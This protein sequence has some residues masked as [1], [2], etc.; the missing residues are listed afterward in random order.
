[1]FALAT[2]VGAWCPGN[3]WCAIRTVRT[4][5][6]FAFET[7]FRVSVI[8]SHAI[9]IPGQRTTF[10]CLAS[11]SFHTLSHNIAYNTRIFTKTIAFWRRNFFREGI[12]CCIIFL[13]SIPV[14]PKKNLNNFW[15]LLHFFL[16]IFLLFFSGMLNH[17]KNHILFLPMDCCEKLAFKFFLESLQTFMRSI[18]YWSSI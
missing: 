16:L 6:F 15:T 4:Y 2:H 7:G 9:L 17:P 11:T 12:V 3:R 5:S 1:M 13:H 8:V 10:K 14:D 18:N